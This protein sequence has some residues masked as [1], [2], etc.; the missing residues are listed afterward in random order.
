[1]R[2]WAH[3]HHQPPLP[4]SAALHS[5]PQQTARNASETRRIGW[6]G[7]PIVRLAPR[8]N[9]PGAG[10]ERRAGA[11]RR[12]AG[13]RGEGRRARVELLLRVVRRGGDAGGHEHRSLS[14]W[15]KGRTSKVCCW[16]RGKGVCGLRERRDGFTAASA[17]ASLLSSR[18]PFTRDDLRTQRHPHSHSRKYSPSSH[19]QA[20]TRSAKNTTNRAGGA[21]GR[22]SDRA[23]ALRPR[24][25]A[26]THRDTPQRARAHQPSIL[27]RAQQESERASERERERGTKKLAR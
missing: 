20:R 22:R 18:C 1:M 5:G 9:V 21:H 17:L 11:T 27:P 4:S 7:A 16:A 2:A 8:A 19:A 6:I 15:G 12:R 14:C 23:R 10:G 25:R 26:R 24:L 3:H 13:E